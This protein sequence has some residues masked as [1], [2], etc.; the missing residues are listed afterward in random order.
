MKLKF[1]LYGLLSI[2]LLFLGF[3]G[4]LFFFASPRENVTS[5]AE[6]VLAPPSEEIKPVI[7]DGARPS[8]A[9]SGKLAIFY[10]GDLSGNLDP[11]G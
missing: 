2:S 7:A 3:M 6:S 9:R 8:A 1:G 10:C 4:Y 11:C 5:G